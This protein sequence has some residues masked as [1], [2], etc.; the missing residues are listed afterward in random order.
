ME[1]EGQS[2]ETFV[3][4]KM[5]DNKERILVDWDPEEAR[6]RLSETLRRCL[7]ESEKSRKEDAS[8]HM[9]KIMYK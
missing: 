9:F 5:E 6:Q 2:L 8:L 3:E 4:W 1:D 7:I